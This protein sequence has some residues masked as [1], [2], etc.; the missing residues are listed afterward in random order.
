MWDCLR[1]FKTPPP[2][3]VNPNSP[4]VT[5]EVLDQLSFEYRYVAYKFGKTFI[6][7][8]PQTLDIKKTIKQLD[9]NGLPLNSAKVVKVEKIYN[10]FVYERIE[11]ELK[12]LIVK[13]QDLSCISQ[14]K[15]LFHGTR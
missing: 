10:T 7:R 1:T 2:R 13:N 9:K 5:V 14:L 3:C 6:G 8:D 11:A 12:R 4:R 15:H